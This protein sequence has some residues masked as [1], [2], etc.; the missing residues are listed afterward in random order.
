MKSIE[1]QRVELQQLH[2]QEENLEYELNEVQYKIRLLRQELWDRYMTVFKSQGLKWDAK[3]IPNDDFRSYCEI[4]AKNDSEMRIW[5]DEDLVRIKTFLY[6]NL[7][8]E[9]GMINLMTYDI[10]GIQGGADFDIPFP[11]ELCIGMQR[12][13][14]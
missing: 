10:S 14:K 8:L 1:E 12:K 9:K 3:L 7:D 6:Y 5:I 11:V 4:L 13:G 2:V